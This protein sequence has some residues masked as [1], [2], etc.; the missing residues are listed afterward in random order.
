MTCKPVSHRNFRIIAITIIALWNAV[1]AFTQQNL[2][3]GYSNPNQDTV[4]S[5][6]TA[7]FDTILVMNHSKLS[8]QNSHIAVKNMLVVN[9]SAVLSVAHS[10]LK[11]TGSCVFYGES[12]S[13]FRDT[14]TLNAN[15]ICGARANLTIDSAYVVSEMSFM[16]QYEILGFDKGQIHFKNSTF[17]LNNGK[18]GGG[19][20]DQARFYQ[21]NNLFVTD[22]GIGMTLGFLNGSQFDVA[23][24]FGGMEII[25]NDSAS[26][27]IEGSNKIILWLG[28]SKGDTVD[29]DLPETNK[30]FP[31]S[32]NVLNFSFSNA[33][34]NV[35]GIDYTVDMANCDTV[36]WSLL[37]GK[38]CH[39]TMNNDSL[40]AIGLVYDEQACDT[41]KGIT[42]KNLYENE[43]VMLSDR[44][45]SLNNSLVYAWNFYPGDSS[46]LILEDCIF[47]EIL[48]SADAKAQLINST[49]D[50]SGG[51][52]GASG[53]SQIYAKHSQIQRMYDGPPI[54]LNSGHSLTVFESCSVEGDIILNQQAKLVQS[55]TRHSD[56]IIL[57]QESY[58]L[59]ISLDT[60]QDVSAG[61]LADITGS[62]FDS[63]GAAGT[64][65]ITGFRLFYTTSGS[66]YPV[67][68]IDTACQPT[69]NN[70]LIYTWNSS[71]LEDGEYIIWLTVYV[72]GDS[73]AT[74]TSNA[75]LKNKTSITGQ[76][77]DLALIT[78]C[79]N[80]AT[81]YIYIQKP[82][83][84]HNFKI[85][86]L[87]LYGSTLIENR[88]KNRIDISSLE[89]GTYVVRLIEGKNT[90][91]RLLIKN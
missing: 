73:M 23:D 54:I 34:P 9:D 25:V 3:V 17:N 88:N 81:K 6:I 18:F 22:I 82:G 47:G 13:D 36:F 31:P 66:L 52:V 26:I 61:T 28:L 68:I 58:L 49:C 63:K 62:L 65:S 1:M 42:N 32:S 67:T 64:D 79:P 14:L 21:N 38:G 4:L 56:Q 80:P 72:N 48:T 60:I 70:D 19:F 5:G 33:L 40:L 30:S 45:L 43:A 2:V 86:I 39:V 11:V 74:T 27:N 37:L 46:Q 41:I 20:R 35:Q 24:C 90:I 53:H 29:I 8:I 84:F 10:N 44:N 55:S 87:N 75:I 50:G 15:L 51:Y 71:G 78:I 69:I 91:S 77:Q 59:N 57:N 76:L 89:P 83:Y 12:M 16:G 7:N 85:Q